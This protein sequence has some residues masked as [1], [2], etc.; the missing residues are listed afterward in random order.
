VTGGSGVKNGSPAAYFGNV[1]SAISSVL[2]GESGAPDTLTVGYST[3]ISKAW[4]MYGQLYTRT[5]GELVVNP[6]GRF[7]GPALVTTS[8]SPSTTLTGN[9]NPFAG[10]SVGDLL[11]IDNGATD[12]YERKVTARASSESVTLDSAIN[13]PSA[14]AKWTYKK[15]Y[16]STN[17][18]HRL[19]I[20]TRGWTSITAVF[21]N[22][23]GTNTG[24]VISS[25]E[26]TASPDF[27]YGV[28]EKDTL[29]VGSGTTGVDESALDL[30]LAAY[31]FCRFSLRF[32]TNDD[33]D[34]TG[35]ATE[36]ADA[37]V[38]FNGRR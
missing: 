24:G 1:T 15:F 6:F 20:D 7:A 22:T 2:T 9:P 11:F 12:P 34:A 37:V 18:T 32:G 4:G 14:G 27:S 35:A 33:A 29:T 3:S 38:L 28:I 30:T 10:V 31:P 26:C 36:S 16:L 21:D 23:S 5:N 8:G 19:W 13:I 17:P 25:W